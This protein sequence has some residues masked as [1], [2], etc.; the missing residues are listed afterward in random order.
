MRLKPP[1]NTVFLAFLVGIFFGHHKGSSSIVA[2]PKALTYSLACQFSYG[3]FN[4]AIGWPTCANSDGGSILIRQPFLLLLIGS[5]SPRFSILQ[6]EV[7]ETWKRS[8]E[9][10]EILCCLTGVSP[11]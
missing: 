8:L 10:T 1:T 4:A 7:E 11:W 3:Y 5:A 2:F 6:T 9:R